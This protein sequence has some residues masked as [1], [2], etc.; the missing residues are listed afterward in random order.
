MAFIE[1]GIF[2]RRL[3]RLYN[4]FRS[5]EIWQ[6]VDAISIPLEAT[7]EETSFNK[8]VLYS[9]LFRFKTHRSSAFFIHLF[10]RELPGSLL[11]LCEGALHVLASTKKCVMLEAL[12]NDSPKMEVALVIHRLFRIFE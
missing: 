5:D 12:Q 9:F 4:S 3:S 2:W 7:S 8:S 11:V 1:A 6:N 10:G